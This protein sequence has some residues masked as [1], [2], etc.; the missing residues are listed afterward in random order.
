M[1]RKF[2][3]SDSDGGTLAKFATSVL[4]PAYVFGSLVGLDSETLSFS[5]GIRIAAAVLFAAAVVFFAYRRFWRDPYAFVAA[6]RNFRSL[7]IPLLYFRFYDS[8]LQEVAVF[9]V[10]GMA[11]FESFASFTAGSKPS[12]SP[13]FATTFFAAFGLGSL[14]YCAGTSG[15]IDYSILN[16]GSLVGKGVAGY[17]YSVLSLF[18]IGYAVA[19]A[20][21]SGRIRTEFRSALPILASQ[22]LVWP[23]VMAAI[24]ALDAG[25]SGFVTDGAPE[26]ATALA[27]LSFMP[28]SVTSAAISARSGQTLPAKWVAASILLFLLYCP[29][30]L[31]TSFAMPAL[32]VLDLPD[33]EVQSR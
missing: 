2:V 11:V 8:V 21:A 10:L 5:S 16:F 13:V 24:L 9:A 17:A 1:V 26:I 20:L 15:W 28:A 27:L 33:A 18:F 32:S 29:I 7:G 25:F 23:A 31:G 3:R 4:F 30:M 14:T 6:S 19:P 22:V 12:R